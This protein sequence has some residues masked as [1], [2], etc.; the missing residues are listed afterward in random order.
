MP[1]MA[2]GVGRRTGASHRRTDLRVL[3]SENSG[4][5]ILSPCFITNKEELLCRHPINSLHLVNANLKVRL[6]AGGAH[7][8]LRAMD[9]SKAQLF[10]QTSSLSRPK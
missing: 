5:F 6:L 10:F 7:I 1:R 2:G 8:F 4:L 3:A 9:A